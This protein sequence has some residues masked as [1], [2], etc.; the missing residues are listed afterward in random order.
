MKKEMPRYRNFQKGAVDTSLIMSFFVFFVAAGA[1]FIYFSLYGGSRPVNPPL[2]LQKTFASIS[3]IKSYSAHIK[4]QSEETT[5][6][7][8]PFEGNVLF[9][10]E[11][12]RASGTFEIPFSLEKSAPKVAVAMIF[13]SDGKKFGKLQIE[14]SPSSFPEDWFEMVSGGYAPEQFNQIETTNA[15]LDSLKILREEKDTLVIKGDI[16]KEKLSGIEVFH[17]G[18]SPDMNKTPGDDDKKINVWTDQKTGD[19]RQ[20]QFSSGG[21]S[22][23]VT[24]V[25]TNKA[26]SISEPSVF[27]SAEVW[28]EKQFASALPEH[29]ITEIFI[30][31]YGS[32]KKEYL[33]GVK[34]A[35]QKATGAKVTIMGSGSPLEK[36]APLF[37][38]AHQQFDADALFKSMERTSAKYGD[39]NRFIYVLDV[40]L[41]SPSHLEKGA[42]WYMEKLGSNTALVSSYG[43]EKKNDTAT[44]SA[45]VSTV[46]SRLQKISLHALGTSIGFSISS[47]SD[48]KAC[49]MYPATTLSELDA[50]GSGYCEPEKGLISK[51]FKK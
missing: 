40:S 26:V 15:F 17:F 9:D 42:V 21:Y 29:L 24:L 6:S 36:T 34:S 18:L 50:Q 31:S 13:S 51:I 33:D 48:N 46:I 39:V 30:G 32:I 2:I 1:A 16:K 43:L 4:V 3:S 44:S 25:Q 8:P 45:S 5:K 20:V 41:Y 14:K 38:E 19:L 37:D 35:V 47:S 7:I 49:L 22:V 27:L 23:I 10:T 28:K 11:G 12:N